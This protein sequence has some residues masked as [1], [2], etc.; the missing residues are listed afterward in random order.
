[1]CIFIR[2]ICGDYEY[3]VDCALPPVLGFD[4]G[5]RRGDEWWVKSRVWVMYEQR[6]SMVVSEPLFVCGNRVL[7]LTRR[8]QYLR[9]APSNSTP[10]LLTF[11]VGLSFNVLLRNV[12]FLFF[13]LMTKLCCEV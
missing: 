11:L 10:D 4:V 6:G 1:M 7:R 13:F 2:Y 9:K 5:E 3:A 12:G 8:K